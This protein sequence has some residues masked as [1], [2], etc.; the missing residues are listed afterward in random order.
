MDIDILFSEQC[1]V[2]L[3]LDKPYEK[4]D[5]KKELEYISYDPNNGNL[6]LLGGNKDIKLNIALSDN[7][8][9]ELIK[10]K[11][12]FVIS[13]N[14][15]KEQIKRH[16]GIL[17]PHKTRGTVKA[18]DPKVFNN[19]NL[20]FESCYFAQPV[21]RSR[22]RKKL[23]RNALVLP[24]L[25]ETTTEALLRSKEV[26]KFPK[27][28]SVYT[29]SISYHDIIEQKTAT[30]ENSQK[31]E[32]EEA[33]EEKTKKRKQKTEIKKSPQ[34]FFSREEEAETLKEA[35]KEQM[36]QS[37]L[38]TNVDALSLPLSSYIGMNPLKE[39]IKSIISLVQANKIRNINDMS[40]PPVSLHMIFKGSPG[41]GKTSAAREIANIM[42][43][44]EHLEK[45]HLVETT[46]DDMRRNGAEAIISKAI[47]GVL[48][49]DEAYSFFEKEWEEYSPAIAVLLKKME[50]SRNNM[51]VIMAGY[52]N[53]INH[54]VQTNP[55]IASRFPIHIDF[56]DYT[57][58][59]MVQ[60]FQKLCTDNQYTI[61]NKALTSIK[62]I[63]QT[64]QDFNSP[65]SFGNG[66]GVRN[67]FEKTIFNQSLRI[68]SEK[69]SSPEDIAAIT[70]D[71]VLLGQKVTID[72]SPK[73]IE[74][75]MTPLNELIGLDNIKT[76]IHDLIHLIHA[77][78]IRQS[79]KLPITDIALHSLFMGPPG[80]G[81]TSV[82][83]ILGRIL[84]DIGF[85]KKGHVVEVDKEKLT[86][87]YIGWS[88]KIAAEKFKEAEGGI[89][90][91]DE[92]YNL[93]GSHNEKSNSFAEES[94]NTIL[95]LME[96]N[97]NKVMVICAGYEKEMKQFLKSNSGLESRF[98]RHLTFKS[99]KT[100]EMVSIFKKLCDDNQYKPTPAALK[101]LGDHLSTMQED[102]INKAGNGRYIRNIFE[103]TMISQSR[104][105]T[106]GTLDVSNTKTLT[107]ITEEDIS[108]PALTETDKKMGFF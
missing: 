80:T 62:H 2:C 49:I 19:T 43:N 23:D 12:I 60:I 82:A 24:D 52:T 65:H 48:F 47:G 8:I 86:G 91:I 51:I 33:E 59:E 26:K 85:L 22:Q 67:L 92:A 57:T 50:D 94:L 15:D 14:N 101:K 21:H 46:P 89:L 44:L 102:A 10:F 95:K 78:K 25:T 100:D 37:V 70:E 93:T 68:V 7:M 29:P 11:R 31:I 4:L 90:F 72:T 39:K 106:L 76:D 84:K 104:R 53:E 63:L 40:E 105:I 103:K 69:L 73:N 16:L 98:P 30:P 79:A 58:D 107:T 87:R 6:T 97:R 9:T 74:D 17:I 27:I 61:D 99:Y 96:D 56:P 54:L 13:K 5:P 71:D 77:Q 108:F 75:M 45:G 88:A 1:G 38:N 83:R 28:H 81:K 64:S 18:K 36:I 55:G 34:I 20:F 42:K 3:L 32:K 66:R 41:T 35:T